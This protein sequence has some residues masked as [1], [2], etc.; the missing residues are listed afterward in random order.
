[1]WAMTAVVAPICGP[2]IR[3]L[4]RIITLGHG[5]FT[6][7]PVGIFPSQ[8][9][10]LFERTRNAITKPPIDIVGLGIINCWHRLLQVLLDQGNDLDWL[11][12]KLSSHYA[13]ISFIS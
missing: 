6:L 5:F 10:R 12:S 3:W 11:N 8:S 2:V 9:L 13:A 4:I 1:M 7:I